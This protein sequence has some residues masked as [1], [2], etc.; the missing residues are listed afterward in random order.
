[1]TGGALLKAGVSVHTYF[2]LLLKERPHT[3]E[4]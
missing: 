3:V 4:P 2:D 1:M